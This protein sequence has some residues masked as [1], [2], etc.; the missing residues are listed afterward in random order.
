MP[1]CGVSFSELQTRTHLPAP[2]EGEVGAPPSELGLHKPSVQARRTM[3]GALG[4]EMPAYLGPSG[5]ESILGTAVH[6]PVTVAGGSPG[7]SRRLP[8]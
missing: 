2:W 8:L 5:P 1:S 3:A 6:R 4:S 7:L